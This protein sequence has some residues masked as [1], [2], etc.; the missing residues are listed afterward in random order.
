MRG[1]EPLTV[2]QLADRFSLPEYEVLSILARLQEKGLVERTDRKD[3]VY[4]PAKD[5]DTL[6]VGDIVAAIAGEALESPDGLNQDPDAARVGEI[7]DAARE[8]VQTKLRSSVR[9]LTPLAK[10]PRPASEKESEPADSD[11]ADSSAAPQ[12]PAADERG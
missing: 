3:V 12:K 8:A 10:H 6:S 4:L 5:L 1:Q 9:S 7:F 2:L 11:T